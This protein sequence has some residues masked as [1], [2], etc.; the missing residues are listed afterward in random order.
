MKTY[1]QSPWSLSDLFP[2]HDSPEMEA[3][4]TELESQVA[5]FETLRPQLVDDI[6]SDAFLDLLHRQETI[7]ALAPASAPLPACRFPPT[8]K[9]R[10]SR[11]F[12][13]VWI[14]PWRG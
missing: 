2:S 11:P 5:S 10:P 14:R 6:P 8:P 7:Y 1:T 12:W 13:A 9:T 4:F 3:A